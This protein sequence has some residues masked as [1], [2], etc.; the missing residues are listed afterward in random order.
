MKNLED[1]I[2]KITKI[3]IPEQE[4][5]NS[6]MF[7]PASEHSTSFMLQ[8]QPNTESVNLASPL[9]STPI[10]TASFE[11]FH[12][13]NQPTNHFVMSTSNYRSINLPDPSGSSTP[14]CSSLSSP[15][16]PAEQPMF[17]YDHLISGAT[18]TQ[19][20]VCHRCISCHHYTVDF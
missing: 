2:T 3:V 10:S 8:Q 9:T 17:Q 16:V 18:C 12:T 1:L 6:S 4:L 5:R 15:H 20:K 14:T 11:A 13:R 19:L 7:I